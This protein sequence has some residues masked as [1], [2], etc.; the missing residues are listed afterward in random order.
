MK[1]RNLFLGLTAAIA[2]LFF[3]ACEMDNVKPKGN[4]YGILPEHFKVDIP[5][6]L[7]NSSFKTTLL[8]STETDTVR[9]NHIYWHLNTFIAVGEGAADIV[10]AVIWSIHFYNIGDVLYLNYT[11]DEDNRVKNL[12]VIKNVEFREREWE[13]QLTITD[14]GSEGNADG[15]FGLQ[16][17]WNRNPIEGIALF[18]PYNLNR[19]KNTDAD[20]ALFS[21]EYSEKGTDD[22]DAYMIVEIAGLPLPG[23]KLQPFA[24]ETLKMF[25]GRKG[26]IVEVFG[27]SN[28]P[29]AQFNP[30]DNEAVGF[31]WAFVAAGDEGKDIAVAEVGLP[32][33]N[34]DITGRTA[35]LEDNSIKKVLTREMTNYIV[36]EYAEAGITLNPEEIAMFLTPYLKNADAP[37]YF[38]SNGF[39]QGGVATG[40]GYS[41]LESSIGKLVPYNPYEI[42]NLTISFK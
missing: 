13:Y 31:N 1:T 20:K 27:N 3:T 21:I 32:A 23:A 2:A 28:H 6:S 35:I 15:G 34:A 7:S 22:Y 5:N 36:A 14:A 37:G 11:S 4:E 10:E 18:K 8:K 29:N 24:M 42:S 16:V 26:D 33:S 30:N 9:G 41:E 19:K 38:N 12:E 25:V 39:I 17:F 40:E